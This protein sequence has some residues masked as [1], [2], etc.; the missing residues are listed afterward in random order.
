MSGK[1]ELV[2]TISKKGYELVKAGKA[3]I[4]SGGLR[5]QDGSLLEL[6]KP[7]V[8][9]ISKSITSPLTLASSL[10]NNVQSGFIQHGVNQANQKLDLSL[11]KL[12][13]L[14]RA[15]SALASQ[16]NALSW[17]SC[18]FSMANC[19]ISI[20]GFYMTLKKMDQ[21]SAQIS[22]LSD[23]IN[24]AIINDMLERYDKYRLN[25]SSDVGLLQTFKPEVTKTPSFGANLNEIAAFLKR[26]ISEFE[27]RTI[28]GVLGCNM[29][30]GLAVPFA[31]EVREYS[32]QFYYENSCYPANYDNW[33]KILEQID[34]E[35][36][37][38]LLKSF[39]VFDHPELR[40]EARYTAFTGGM[41]SVQLQLGNLAY[42]REL[43]KQLPRGDYIKLDDI[44]SKKLQRHCFTTDGDLVCI[45]LT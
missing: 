34:S 10:A 8:Q 15:V 9:G 20:A 41:G 23:K 4:S 6:A 29:I 16:S 1:V 21:I 14:E 28:D 13:S 24:R 42:S 38:R 2:Y 35:T 33:V 45:P 17:V 18:A 7:A 27:L 19:G 31:Q 26:V 39:L 32:T 22:A 40:M 36:F 11:E 25:L 3:V 12:D 43:V 37:Q 30:F 5:T 44:L